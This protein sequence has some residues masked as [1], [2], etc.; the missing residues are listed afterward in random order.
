MGL[1]DFLNSDDARLGIGLLAA[2]GYT[3]TKQSFG[4]RMA[5]A[6]QGEDARKQEALKALILN[7]QIEDIKQKGEFEKQQR[8]LLLSEL[9]LKNQ[10]HKLLGDIVGGLMG[11]PV[12]TGTATPQP[13]AAD[14]T[15]PPVAAPDDGFDRDLQMAR[16]LSLLDPAKGRAQMEAMKLKYPD[17][18]EHQGIIYHPRTGQPVTIMPYGSPAGPVI[19]YSKLPGG[20]FGVFTP[21][22]ANEALREQTRIKEQEAARFKP[23]EI[24]PTGPNVPPE[25]RPLSDVLSGGAVPANEATF[26]QSPEFAGLP[27]PQQDAIRAIVSGQAP[28]AAV[29]AGGAAIALPPAGAPQPAGAP[30]IAGPSIAQLPR[31]G[32]VIGPTPNA[33][34]SME[35]N[36][37]FQLGDA[38]S[39]QVMYE[40]FQKAATANAAKIAKME[41]IGSLLADYNGGKLAQTGYELARL[42]TSIGIKIDP[43]LPNK[44]A[45]NA[46]TNEVALTLRSTADG[47]GMPGA[48]SDADR[49]FLKSMTPQLGQTAKGRQLL[50]ESNVAALRREQQIASMARQYRQKHGIVDD[51]FYTQLQAWSERNPIFKNA[52]R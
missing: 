5:G 8:P 35:A 14:A 29:P 38:K 44:E 20:G 12:S 43:D 45:A 9:Q 24:K 37:E 27:K 26:L 34:A 15:A 50:I 52:S 13:S 51:D 49:E 39:K 33:S 4:Q 36:R 7:A 16:A 42:G 1:L 19:Q 30:A 25:V 28:R 23:Y 10:Q 47:N 2:G 46:L 31:G 40:N 22:G 17:M 21:P 11:A 3:P 32:T 18:K 6:F 41:R 48:M